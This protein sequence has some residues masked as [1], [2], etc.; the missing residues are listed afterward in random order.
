MEHEQ[1]DALQL[2]DWCEGNRS[3]HGHSESVAKELRRL[4]ARNQELESRRSADTAG[5]LF[6]FAGYL[7]TLPAKAAFPVGSHHS[8][9]PMVEA[10]KAWAKTRALSLE[11]ADVVGWDE[12]KKTA[13][14]VVVREVSFTEREEFE[15]WWMLSPKTS[16]RRPARLP[17][18]QYANSLADHAWNGWQGRAAATID[19][20]EGMLE[21]VAAPDGWKLVPVE[22]TPEMEAAYYD[23][24]KGVG[25]A[26]EWGAMLDAAPNV[27]APMMG[28]APPAT[29]P[30]VLP[31]P[32][33]YQYRMKPNWDDKLPW[34]PWEACSKE[35]AANLRKRKEIHDWIYEVRE[36]Y[37]EQQVR[38]LL[39]AQP[40]SATADYLDGVNIGRLRKSLVHLGHASGVGDEEVAADLAGHVNALTRELLDMASAPKP[41]VHVFATCDEL[42][43]ESCGQKRVR[44]IDGEALP[45]RLYEEPPQPQADAETLAQAYERGRR[46][47]FHNRVAAYM[48]AKEQFTI[49]DALDAERYRW[50]RNCD[51]ETRDNGDVFVGC[52]KGKIVLNGA[53]LDAIVGAAI[54]AAKGE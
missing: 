30:G 24:R 35:S 5:A 15:A 29:A 36:R 53:D 28:M 51:V 16:N 20:T 11:S 48:E 10:L 49:A 43:C 8:A 50:L 44:R 45:D 1:M 2:A 26:A 42:F 23:P 39:S 47:G 34:T 52:A 18:G 4:H 14:P 40:E 7:T 46:H 17:D 32:D 3:V 41:N 37:T 12:G 21:K 31:E 13:P 27:D 54:T 33:E 25:A 38:E 6:D 19:L 22:V 9:E